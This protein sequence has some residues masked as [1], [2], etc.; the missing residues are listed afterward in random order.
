[1]EP[2]RPPLSDAPLFAGLVITVLG[3]ADIITVPVRTGSTA[4]LSPAINLPA[5]LLAIDFPQ[6]VFGLARAGQRYVG[7][8]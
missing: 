2:L 1:L 3:I 5:L 8:V 4:P 6:W 7:P